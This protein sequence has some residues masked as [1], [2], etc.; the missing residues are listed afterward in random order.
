MPKSAGPAK[1]APLNFAFATEGG[2]AKIGAIREVGL[3]RNSV[4]R[5]EAGSR[6][7]AS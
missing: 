6:N 7:F 3:V 2:S 4:S 5:K 1:T